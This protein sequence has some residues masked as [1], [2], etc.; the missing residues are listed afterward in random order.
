MPGDILADATP[1]FQQELYQAFDL[2]A[3]YDKTSH[4]VSIGAT[5]TDSTPHAVAAIIAGADGTADTRPQPDFSDLAQ[6]PMCGFRSQM[7]EAGI[8]V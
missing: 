5:I 7:M 3:R 6:A 2:Q 8:P 1:C 4:Q